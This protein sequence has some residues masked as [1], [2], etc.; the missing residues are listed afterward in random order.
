MS[1]A[2]ADFADSVQLQPRVSVTFA[3]IAILELYFVNARGL[4]P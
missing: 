1:M 3:S 4:Y 2:D